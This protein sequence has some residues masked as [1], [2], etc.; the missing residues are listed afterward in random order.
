M[1]DRTPAAADALAL[2]TPEEMARADAFAA[3]AGRSTDA[4]MQA[5]GEAVAAAIIAHWSPRKTLI[6]CG[7]GNNGGDGFVAARVLQDAGWPVRVA[8]LG[9]RDALKGAAGHHARRWTGEAAPISPAVVSDAELA[10]DAIFGAG[11]AR[12]VTGAAAETL[13]A[14][15]A[16]AIPVVAIDVPSGVDG[17]TG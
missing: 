10:V 6:L 13:A 12:P 3:A 16:R 15:A 1:L 4:L 5:A 17:A 14:V 2:L 9:A 8:L 11:L 7:P